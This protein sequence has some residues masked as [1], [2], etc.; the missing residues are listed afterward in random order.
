MQWCILKTNQYFAS[1]RFQFQLHRDKCASSIPTFFEG[2]V[3]FVFKLVFHSTTTLVEGHDDIFCCV[4]QSCSVACTLRFF[5]IL[6]EQTSP[7]GKVNSGHNTCA[8][9]VVFTI[10]GVDIL[11]AVFIGIC[12]CCVNRTACHFF[13]HLNNCGVWCHCNDVFV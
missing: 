4:L 1:F 6:K 8:Y 13:L 7:I 9:V 3:V 2:R 5:W 10:A 12:F 11:L